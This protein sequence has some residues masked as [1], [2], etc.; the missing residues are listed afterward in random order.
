[1]RSRTSSVPTLYGLLFAAF[2]G[3]MVIALLM[4]W[5]CLFLSLVVYRRCFLSTGYSAVAVP[6]GFQA[7]ASR[8]A[9]YDVSLLVVCPV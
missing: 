9:M 5:L 8:I 2:S 6:G 7:F 1:M 3:T 4:F